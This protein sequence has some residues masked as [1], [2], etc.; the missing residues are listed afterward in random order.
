MHHKLVCQ[1]QNSKT[2]EAAQ[3][4]CC[5]KYIG[6]L[7]TETNL[8][9]WMKNQHRHY[10]HALQ[11]SAVTAMQVEMGSMPLRIRQVKLLMTCWV[12]LQGH[13]ESNV[14]SFG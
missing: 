3:R 5:L 13:N 11:T 9:K 1:P 12:T 10:E 4:L 2:Q 14:W 8:K 7:A 6:R